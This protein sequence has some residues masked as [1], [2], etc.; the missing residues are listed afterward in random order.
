LQKG[1]VLKF[2]A[3]GRTFNSNVGVRTYPRQTYGVS[4]ESPEE[5]R[6]K[7]SL[8]GEHSY[9]YAHE[10]KEQFEYPS[11]RHF[12][13]VHRCQHLGESSELPGNFSRNEVAFHRKKGRLS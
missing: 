9:V 13:D 7:H 2:I 1:H 10:G 5:F 11:Q 6:Q 8:T 12:F 3:Q 4:E